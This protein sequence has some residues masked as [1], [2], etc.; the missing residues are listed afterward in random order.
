MIWWNPVKHQSFIERSGG[1]RPHLRE[2]SSQNCLTAGFWFNFFNFVT[3]GDSQTKVPWHSSGFMTGSSFWSVNALLNF[4]QSCWFTQ[5][6]TGFIHSKIPIMHC[7]YCCTFSGLS[8]WS[9]VARVN[10]ASAEQMETE[11]VGVDCGGSGSARNVGP[12][13]HLRPDNEQTSES[14]RQQL[15]DGV[16]DRKG[17]VFLCLRLQ[18]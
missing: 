18:V 5:T 13:S 11:A 3:R 6:C 17:A 12:E 1:K 15:N 2:T 9:T 14:L 4:M 7:L 10:Y 16:D 8:D